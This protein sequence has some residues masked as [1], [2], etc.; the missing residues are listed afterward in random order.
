[1]IFNMMGGGKGQD[2]SITAYT[3]TLAAANWTEAEGGFEQTVP[4]ATATALET[5]IIEAQPRDGLAAWTY[6]IQPVAQG[7]GTVTFKALHLPTADMV[8][9]ITVLNPNAVYVDTVVTAI[10]EHDRDAGA[11]GNI[12]IDGNDWGNG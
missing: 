3:V 4:V 11:H 12:N 5:C 9:G 7:A 1:M 6:D 10:A 8:Y 2:A